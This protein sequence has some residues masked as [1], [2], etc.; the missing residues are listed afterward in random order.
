MGDVKNSAWCA[1]SPLF[2]GKGSSMQTLAYFV[3][4][5]KYVE[6]EAASGRGM[7]SPPVDVCAHV[8]A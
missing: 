2:S 3:S 4:G 7:Y 1:V 6:E 8:S 5:R